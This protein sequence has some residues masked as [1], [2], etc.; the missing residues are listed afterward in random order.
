VEPYP[1]V[2]VALARQ[3][4]RAEAHANR[5]FVEA[6]ARLSPEVGAAWIDVDGAYAMFDGV[7]SPLTQTFG[8]GMFSPLTPDALRRIETFFS[9]RGAPAFHEVSPLADPATWPLLSTAGYE[10]FEF[11]SVMFRP[12]GDVPP[13]R[14]SD[15]LTTRLAGQEGD[16]WSELS[17]QG[18]SEYPELS[19]FLRDMGRVSANAED[20]HCFVAELEGVPIATGMTIVHDS[21]VLL[22]GASTIPQGR[23][24]GAQNALLAHRLQDGRA[25]GARL[26]MMCAQPGSASQRN[27]E[28]Q[29]FRIAY[30]RLKWRKRAAERITR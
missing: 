9:D 26:A 16:L 8:A 2:D 11:T 17:V 24:K 18:W 5:R 6:R 23:R 12:I 19:G 7:A 14:R 28:R 15:G 25:R 29:G 10:P 13:P 3:L 27:A 20:A 22:A 30:T 4:E 1:F 21:V